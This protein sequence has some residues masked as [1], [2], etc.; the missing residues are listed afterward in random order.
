M[1]WE[2]IQIVLMLKEVV[3]A[4][5]VVDTAMEDAVTTAELE[6]RWKVVEPYVTV[7]ESVIKAFFSSTTLAMGQLSASKPTEA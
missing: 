5:G 4:E 6:F 1:W 2:M 7:V 3:V